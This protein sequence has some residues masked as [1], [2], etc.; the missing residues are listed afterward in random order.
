MK[1]LLLLL[2]F[3]FALVEIYS[4]VIFISEHKALPKS[5]QHE[6]NLHIYWELHQKWDVVYPTL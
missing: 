6:H 4:Q 2:I 5:A 1:L 3:V